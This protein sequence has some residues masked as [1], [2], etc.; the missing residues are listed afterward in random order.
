MEDTHIPKNYN[1]KLECRHGVGSSKLRWLDDI[2]TLRIKRWR[3]KY[4]DTNKWTVI[5]REATA[6]L[7]KRAI[8]PEEEEYV[9]E[10]VGK[11]QRVKEKFLEWFKQT[12]AGCRSTDEQKSPAHCSAFLARRELEHGLNKSG[13]INVSLWHYRLLLNRICLFEVT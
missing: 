12:S 3:L 11:Y 4:Q 5:L 10:T 2:K 6:I 7:R 13:L 9:T 1:I 8:K